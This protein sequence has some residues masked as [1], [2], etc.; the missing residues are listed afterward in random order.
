MECAL[1][2]L[3]EKLLLARNVS[4]NSG[5][6]IVEYQIGDTGVSDVF[7]PLC[8][9]VAVSASFVALAARLFLRFLAIVRS[10]TAPQLT[11]FQA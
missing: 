4:K 8:Y 1:R 10:M 7:Q 2:D 6:P 3:A 11:H 9:T 5:P